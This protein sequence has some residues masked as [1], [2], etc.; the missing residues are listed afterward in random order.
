MFT[1]IPVKSLPSQNIHQ[2]RNCNQKDEHTK[3][4]INIFRKKTKVYA[5]KKKKK[6]QKKKITLFDISFL[7][8]DFFFFF[9]HKKY[10]FFCK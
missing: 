8:F 5:T 1:L 7:D 9:L 10:I 4:Y 2:G 3:N 6:K